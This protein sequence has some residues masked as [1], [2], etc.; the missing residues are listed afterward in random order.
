[1]RS[2]ILLLFAF[3]LGICVVKAQVK[4]LDSVIVHGNEGKAGLSHLHDVEG[5]AI[6]AGRTVRRIWLGKGLR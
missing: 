1:M 4:E 3:C 2:F 6:Y 5:T